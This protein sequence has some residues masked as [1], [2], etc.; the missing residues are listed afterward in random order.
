MDLLL[1]Y[2]VAN[3]VGTSLSVFLKWQYSI[4]I[5]LCTVKE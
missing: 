1:I 5:V 3:I 4:G 2:F